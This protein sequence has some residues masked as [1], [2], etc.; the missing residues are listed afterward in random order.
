LSTLR[1]WALA[2]TAELDT[3]RRQSTFLR[4]PLPAGDGVCAVCRGS[5][6]PGY[7][8]CYQCEQHR[9]IARS[10]LA[11]VVAPISY[12]V[13]GSQH[14]HNLAVYKATPPSVQAQRNLSSLAI[15]HTAFHWGCYAAALG[16]PLTH[17]ATVP[18]TRARQGTHPIDSVVAARLSLPRIDATANPRYPSDD[19]S[20]HPDRFM[21]RMPSFGQQVRILLI[22]DTWTT[23]SRIQS[24]A[25]ALKQAGAA[26]VAAVL[27]GRHVNPNYD[28]SKALVGALRTGPGFD[29]GKCVVDDFAA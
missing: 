28:G 29:L 20:F 8:I 1:E 12:A 11:D 17:V 21:V 13:K 16:G 19:R 6:S 7:R 2:Q 22:D 25:Y 15:L 10:G 18:S 27:L 3:V 26:A 9:M 5:A 24:L 14:A 4:N 23:G